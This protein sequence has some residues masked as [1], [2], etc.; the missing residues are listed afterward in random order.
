M[1]QVDCIL[2]TVAIAYNYFLIFSV[3]NLLMKVLLD[4]ISVVMHWLIQI[5]Q[6]LIYFIYKLLKIFM[7]V[8]LI[9]L[10]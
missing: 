5:F 4:V 3:Q 6:E 8:G 9:Y 10:Y 7:Y 2:F 1:S